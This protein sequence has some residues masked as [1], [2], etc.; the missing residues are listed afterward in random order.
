MPTSC[1]LCNNYIQRRKRL[2][3][4]S[5]EDNKKFILLC[6]ECHQMCQAVKGAQQELAICRADPL[7]YARLAEIQLERQIQQLREKLAG[8]QATQIRLRT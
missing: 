4:S 3:V 8:I 5:P 6:R 7:K 2:Q 1:Q